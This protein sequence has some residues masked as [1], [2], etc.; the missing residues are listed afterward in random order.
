MTED[1]WVK[2]YVYSVEV[3]EESGRYRGRIHIKAHRYSG[4]TFEP[5]IVIDTPALFKRGHAAEI[6]ARALARELIDG[7]HLE[8]HITAIRQEAALPVTP[9]AQPLSDTSSHTE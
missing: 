3:A 1:I 6:E 5:P 8:E 9:A 2:G 4:R 7:G